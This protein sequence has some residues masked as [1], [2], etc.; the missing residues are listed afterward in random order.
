MSD[1]ISGIVSIIYLNISFIF[2]LASNLKAKTKER[3][4]DFINNFE[5]DKEII[6]IRARKYFKEFKERS[7]RK[8][9]DLET[10]MKKREEEIEKMDWSWLLIIMPLSLKT[11]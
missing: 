10:R 9:T 6:E 7:Q 1:S 8:Q 3:V 11:K 4:K 2:N 5:R